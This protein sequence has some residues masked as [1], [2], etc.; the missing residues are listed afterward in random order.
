M[1]G[2]IRYIAV[3]ITGL[4]LFCIDAYPQSKVE[5]Q[6]E[7][8][9][10]EAAENINLR[11]LDAA[12][13]ILKDVL[14]VDP[15]S[16]AAWYYLGT[17]YIY[18][19]DLELAREYT[20][21]AVDLDPDNF[22]YR[23]KLAQL[24][25]Y[26]SLDVVVEMYE[27]MIADFPKKTEL[28]MELLEFYMVQKDYEKALK[29]IEEIENTIGPSEELAVYAYRVYYTMNR[30][31]EGLEYLRKYNSRYSSPVVLTILAD[32]ELAMYN[33][34]LAIKYYD[35]AIEL[36]SSYHHALLGKAE[37]CR[38]YHRYGDFFPSLNRYV[39]T[40]TAPVAEKTEYLSTLIEKSDPQFIR[41]F[42]PQLDTTMQKLSLT[43]P[44][45]SLVYNLKG[46][47]YYV[48]GRDDAAIG[49]FRQ[50]AYAYPES[51]GATAS[52]VE[53]LMFL[54]RWEDLSVEGR[55][56]FERFQNE[57]AFLEMAGAG[58]YNLGEYEKVLETCDK[59]LEITPKD[60]PGA[61]RTWSTMGDVYHLMGENKLA[62]KAYDKALKIDPEYI[63]V[64]NNYAYYL[65]LEGKK[66]KKAYEMS[67]KT[68]EAE[69]ENATYLDTYG[70]ILYLRGEYD[71]AKTHFKKAMLHGGKDSAVILDHYADVLYALKDYNMAFVYWT[72]ALQKNDQDDVPGLKEKVQQK[73]KE[74]GR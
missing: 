61:V 63:Y 30:L 49:Q 39:E 66:L 67:R 1:S 53:I 54:S 52:Y 70:W 47:Y 2:K 10:L 44:G 58:D 64:L 56:A 18:R 5:R 38:M 8:M 57:P 55:K 23:Y 31:E 68:V 62:Y 36:D 42:T 60:D 25:M 69:P 27:K 28:N 7:N 26:D 59:I 17:I 50:R 41:R 21:K 12:E 33:D 15:A 13:S 45:D 4:L 43:H 46:V 29:T 6:L 3:L 74:A 11:K 16:D 22:W 72:M 34:S 19:S 51:L 9:V 24:Y 73:R 65:S 71:Q 20:S 37:A 48:T 32:S 35:E 40:R 14:A